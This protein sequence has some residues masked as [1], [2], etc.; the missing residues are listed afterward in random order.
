M[1][2]NLRREARLLAIVALAA[3][4]T[5]AV[6]HGCGSASGSTTTIRRQVALRDIAAV[7]ILPTYRAFEERVAELVDASMELQSHPDDETL[8]AAREAWRAA[9][10]VWRQ[11]IAFE[12]GPAK[13]L[14][15]SVKIDWAPI[16][17]ERI[18]AEIAGTVPLT[19][20]FVESLGANAKGFLAMEYLLFDPRGDAAVLDSLSGA[21]NERRRGY[22]VALA[23]NMLSQAEA[24][25]NAWEPG[26]GGFV[27]ELALAGNGSS[28]FAT[29][30]SG[31][32]EVV[33]ALVLASRD[34][35]VRRLGE[36]LGVAD[37]GMLHPEAITTLRSAG[38]VTDIVDALVGIRNVYLAKYNGGRGDGLSE[39]VWNLS[40]EMDQSIRLAL[41][42][43][44][45]EAR[46]IDRPLNEAIRDER[47]QV[48]SAYE[49]ART[50]Q[51]ALEIDLVSILGSTLRFNPGDGD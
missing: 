13:E 20:D 26:G 22:L 9:R 16:R 31:L 33:N 8:R 1:N 18:E 2:R 29:L 10:G 32:D 50:V 3:S 30:Q 25:A 17:S 46:A 47:E 45:R 24:L 6:L 7:V 51:R 19:G 12:F 5:V 28:V 27:G 35:A 38:G 41:D 49:R 11:S 39:I 4:V 44:I 15:T 23:E 40:W 14:R 48:E 34:V 37:G 36:P 21:A 43:A 42:L